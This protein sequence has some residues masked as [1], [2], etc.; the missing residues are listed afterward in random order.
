MLKAFQPSELHKLY[1]WVLWRNTV[2]PVDHWVGFFVQAI[3]T[4]KG[5]I[6]NLADPVNSN[7]W[8]SSTNSGKVKFSIIFGF[9]F[10]LFFYC[11]TLLFVNV[12]SSETKCKT[13]QL[14]LC[15]AETKEMEKTLFFNPNTLEES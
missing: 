8:A 2:L 5:P 7:A 9:F 3:V 1:F 13:P 14:K 6:E 4:G 12:I 10:L 11:P 15:I